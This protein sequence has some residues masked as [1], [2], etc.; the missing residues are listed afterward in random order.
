MKVREL[1]AIGKL[2]GMCGLGKMKGLC[3]QGE[4]CDKKSGGGV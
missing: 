4:P 1:S 3:C 2:L